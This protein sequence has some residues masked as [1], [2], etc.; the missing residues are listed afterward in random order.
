LKDEFCGALRLIII[1]ERRAAPPC[2]WR[3]Q[4]HAGTFFVGGTHAD[5][6]LGSKRIFAAARG[7]LDLPGRVGL[8]SIIG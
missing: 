1:L 8:A 4:W 2:L 3:S 6:G 7:T 5:F